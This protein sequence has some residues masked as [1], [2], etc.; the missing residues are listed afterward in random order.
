MPANMVARL[1]G[2]GC[3]LLGVLLLFGVAHQFSHP[4]N[5]AECLVCA[6]LPGGRHGSDAPA[7]HVRLT[8]VDAR[9]AGVF[10][11]KSQATHRHF[12]R[13]QILETPK[14]SE[15]ISNPSLASQPTLL[16]SIAPRAPPVATSA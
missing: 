3:A 1:R 9:I 16:D 14:R 12:E 10:A 11:R 15:P 8:R 13:L 7:T 2:L 6:A 4:D 5:R